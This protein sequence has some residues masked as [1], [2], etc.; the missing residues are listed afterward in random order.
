MIIVVLIILGL[1]FGSFVN[2][3]TWRVHKKKDWVRARSQCTHCGHLL[4]GLDLIPVL[5][6]VLLRGKCRYCHKPISVQYPLVELVGAIGFTISYLYW[7]GDLSNTSQ[8][9]LFIAWLA[10]SIGLLALLVYDFRWMLLPNKLIYPTLAVAAAGNLAYLALVH[11]KYH[12]LLSWIL[13]VAVASGIFWLLFTVSKGEWIGYGDV[14]LG[15][16]TGTLLHSPSHSF[17]MIFT[18]SILGSLFVAPSL[19]S[20]SRVLTARLPFGPF[21]IISTAIC[22]LFGGNIL[23]WYTRL[24]SI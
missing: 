15:L 4:N 22:I 9:V 13:S 23:D 2:A 24:F 11:N 1:C 14:R 16:V 10:A 12:F 18:A 20:K 7:P 3:F 8:L 21:L 5:S 19:L 6:W 17:L